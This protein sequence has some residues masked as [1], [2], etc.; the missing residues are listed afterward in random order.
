MKSKVLKAFDYAFDG[1]RVQRANIGDEIDFLDMTDGLAAEGYIEKGTEVETQAP[2]EP[3][4]P[5]ADDDD[6]PES[7]T[8]EEEES[9]VETPA[10]ATSRKRK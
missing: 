9:E 5:A 4:E 7:E 3:V 2:V 1:I 6:G 8:S 10:P